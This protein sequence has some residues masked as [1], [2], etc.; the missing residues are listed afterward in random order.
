MQWE[1]I[2][3]EAGGV[4][5]FSSCQR[6]SLKEQNAA[7]FFLRHSWCVT[8]ISALLHLQ[9]DGVCMRLV[10]YKSG[11]KLHVWWRLFPHVSFSLLCLV[12]MST[13]G[14][15]EF[16]CVYI[17][18]KENMFVTVSHVVFLLPCG[19]TASKCPNLHLQSW[20]PSKPTTHPVHNRP[21]GGLSADFQMVRSGSGLH[22][23]IA[24][25]AWRYLTLLESSRP[26][27]KL[28]Q[29]RIQ[30]HVKEKVLKVSKFKFL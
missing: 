7:F 22:Q 8:D 14:C 9:D 4:Q 11:T 28:N 29:I 27:T 19:W 26:E 10:N 5:R 6:I 16:N 18:S 2:K 15:W 3:G 1:T 13:G 21:S 25:L 12:H 20:E 24:I 17:L 30:K 23:F